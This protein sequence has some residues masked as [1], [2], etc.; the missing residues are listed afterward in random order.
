M[1]TD[2]NKIASNKIIYTEFL[3]SKYLENSI[4]TP[5]FPADFYRDFYDSNSDI[6]PIWDSKRPFIAIRLTEFTKFVSVF[7]IEQK[8]EKALLLDNKIWIPYSAIYLLTNKQLFCQSESMDYT[9]CLSEWVLKKED[10]FEEL[11]KRTIEDGILKL[12]EENYFE[13]REIE[14]ELSSDFGI[15]RDIYRISETAEYDC[16]SE[17]NFGLRLTE[18]EIIIIKNKLEKINYRNAISMSFGKRTT[19]NSD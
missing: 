11:L 5:Y 3:K 1:K 4:C 16:S 18:E 9:V 2:L 6:K 15:G 12:D 7:Q 13:Y 19:S 8:T 10:L 14:Q 17:I